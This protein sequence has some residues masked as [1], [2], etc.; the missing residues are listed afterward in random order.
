MRLVR[1]KKSKAFSLTEVML[2]AA[3]IGIVSV[4]VLD[5]QHH[6]LKQSRI[7]KVQI[8]AARTAQLLLEDWKSTGGST[9]YNPSDLNLGFSSSAAGSDFTTG[10]SIGGILNNAIYSITINNVPMLVVLAYS[11]VD[12]DEVADTTLRQITAMVRWRM[13]KATGSGGTTL[14]TSPVILTTYVRLDG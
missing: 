5:Y 1:Y 11:D 7:A 6:S 13:G 12:H 8:T 3:V 9:A 4:G 2:T 10:Y 14:C